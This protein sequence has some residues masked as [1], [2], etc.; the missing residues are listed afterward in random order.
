MTATNSENE[1]RERERSVRRTL[2]E[3]FE[4]RRSKGLVVFEGRWLA[5]NEL[6]AVAESI[7]RKSNQQTLE[8]SLL[9]LLLLGAC[10]FL[11]LVLW[12]LVY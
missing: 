11:M 12:T 4:S 3:A 1:T 10:V 9:L 6:A 7:Q 8:L 5:A 2:N